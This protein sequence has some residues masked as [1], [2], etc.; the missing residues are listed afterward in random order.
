MAINSAFMHG[1]ENNLAQL[2]ISKPSQ[3]FTI[4][5]HPIPM[6]SACASICASTC[7][8]GVLGLVGSVFV[9]RSI[10]QQL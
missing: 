1:F 4:L 2:F 8:S 6:A 5:A 9:F 7:V 3:S 10:S